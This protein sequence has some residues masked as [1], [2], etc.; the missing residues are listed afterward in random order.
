KSYRFTMRAHEL[1]DWIRRIRDLGITVTGPLPA[2][3]DKPYFVLEVPFN[4]GN[5]P[6]ASKL[7]RPF[8]DQALGIIVRFGQIL[9]FGYARYE[10]L[11]K[12]EQ[13]NQEL[14]I[15]LAIDRVHTEV[16]AM[17]KSVDW[18][19]VL[20]VMRKELIALGMRFSGCGI[21]IIDEDAQRFRQ[22]I[23]LPA[24]VREKFQPTLPSQPID[25]ETD[26]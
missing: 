24:L 22:H 11:R 5:I 25:D 16:L 19:R 20:N 10:G 8:D 2:S 13:Q 23:I 17:E 15:G 3:S 14:K 18:R 1:T 12:L 26:F 21:N 6:R 7:E 9:S 4:R